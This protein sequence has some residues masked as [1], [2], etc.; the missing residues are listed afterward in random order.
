MREMIRLLGRRTAF[1]KIT[2][3]RNDV[4]DGYKIYKERLKKKSHACQKQKNNGSVKFITK[5]DE[6]ETKD[7]AHQKHL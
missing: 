6:A 7:E 3:K 4:E 5:I 1:L 2:W